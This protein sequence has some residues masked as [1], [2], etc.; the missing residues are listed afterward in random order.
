MVRAAFRYGYAADVRGN[1]IG[2]HPRPS[3]A[4]RFSVNTDPVQQNRFA[5]AAQPIENGGASRQAVP[6]ALPTERS[7]R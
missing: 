6:A 2:F 3:N 5:D 1:F 7:E 4:P